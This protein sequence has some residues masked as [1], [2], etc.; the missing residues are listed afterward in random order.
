MISSSTDDG[1]G[2]DA[3]GNQI[4][5]GIAPTGVAPGASLYSSAYVTTD[6][7]P[8]YDDAILTFQFIATIPNMRAVNHSWG[9]QEADYHTN[10]LNGESKLTMALDWSAYWHDVLHVVSGNQGNMIPIPKDNY[11]GMT[12][13]RSA[14]AADGVYRLVSG[15]NTFDEDAFGDRTSIALLA[16]GDGIEV[17]SVGDAHRIVNGSSYAA[18]HVT[19]TVALLLQNSSTAHQRRHEVMKAVLMN[20]ADKVKGIM[21]MERTVVKGGGG[22]WF[23]ST[24]DTDPNIPLDMQMGTGH[25]NAS[26]A[27]EQFQA[28]EQDPG[29][30]APIGWDY[31]VH[32]DP[33]IP[34]TYSFALNAGDFVSATLVWDRQVFLD[35]PFPN[36]QP[37]NEFIDFGFANLDLYLRSSG[38]SV[39]KAST[40][41][42]SNVE[43]IFAQVPSAGTYTL[44]VFNSEMN[45][46][47]Y[48]IAWWA[49]PD[50]RPAAIPGDFNGDTRVD[51]QDF[52]AWQRGE[53]P[54]PLSAG[55]LADWQNN[56]G[57]GSLA[58]VSV[59]EPNCLALLL[60]IVLVSTLRR[61]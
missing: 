53:S 31:N 45:L 37:G 58:A 43:H 4:A 33:F 27:L 47:P 60:G 28:D 25:L 55:D 1:T 30:V 17:A 39:I 54:T 9:K 48:A 51:G 26:R 20:S 15:G 59:P 23:G 50:E 11:N 56:Y 8:G 7:N 19:G 21:G 13:G 6:V 14:K 36:Y 12:I 16:P 40:S 61:I 57:T 38:G 42:V 10:P 52:L 18:P 46:I 22:T 2:T 49:G 32:D 44:E 41:T 24:A 3:A 34:T 5:N 35:S 29:S